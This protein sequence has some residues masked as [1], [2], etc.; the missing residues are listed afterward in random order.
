MVEPNCKKLINGKG[1]HGFKQED[2]EKSIIKVE[3]IDKKLTTCKGSGDV[4]NQKKIEASCSQ[5]IKS[6][7][8]DHMM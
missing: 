1:S 3:A 7:G 5:R 8:M 4:Q 2:I 6:G